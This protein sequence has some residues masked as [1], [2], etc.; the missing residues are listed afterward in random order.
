MLAWKMYSTAL[1][2]SR[3]EGLV[4]KT[5]VELQPASSISLIRSVPC[6]NYASHRATGEANTASA[7]TTN[8]A[9]VLF[10]QSKA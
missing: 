3:R 4:P 7:S 10:G 2:A 5:Y 9:F 6:K 1:T 8:I